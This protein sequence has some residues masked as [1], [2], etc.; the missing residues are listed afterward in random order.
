M[1]EKVSHVRP[2][3][4]TSQAGGK[5][6][7]KAQDRGLV[8][9]LRNGKEFIDMTRS[10]AFRAWQGLWLLLCEMRSHWKVYSRGVT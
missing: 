7:A 8:G 6:S 3:G 10:W 4:G 5:A 1:N 2:G 9:C